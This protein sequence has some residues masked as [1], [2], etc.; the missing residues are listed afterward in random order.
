MIIYITTCVYV[1][2]LHTNTNAMETSVTE[3]NLSL[4]GIEPGILALL[5]QLVF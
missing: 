5:V 2:R 3:L 1:S 4:S